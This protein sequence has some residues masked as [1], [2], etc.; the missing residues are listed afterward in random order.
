MLYTTAAQ[1]HS[2][3]QIAL[4]LV[5]YTGLGKP[6]ST[7][8]CC[9]CFRRRR[10][11][12]YIPPHQ[13]RCVDARGSCTSI[14]TVTACSCT[15]EARWLRY[16]Y[17]N[18]T[19][20]QCNIAI[21]TQ[22]QPEHQQRCP[23]NFLPAMAQ[24]TLTVGQPPQCRAVYCIITSFAPPPAAPAPLLHSAAVLLAALAGQAPA[25]APA[26]VAVAKSGQMTLLTH[27][28]STL[29]NHVPVFT[30]V[31]SMMARVFHD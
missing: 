15:Y 31:C 20:L 21:A 13:Q 12:R 2:P 19:C 7:C 4:K 24:Q 17:V 9:C 8:D 25:A 30:I 14:V 22:H 28:Q 29:F 16:G 18:G 3:L 5:V 11:R 10:T 23:L 26:A 27:C 6:C 1:S